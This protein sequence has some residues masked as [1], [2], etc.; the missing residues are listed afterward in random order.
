MSQFYYDLH[1]HSCLSPCADNDN[2]P[3]NIAG[4][5]TLN[6]LQIMALTDHNTCKNCPAFFT[7]AQRQGIIPVPGMELTT[8]EDIH[9]VCLFPTLEAAM[10]F[11]G[12]IDRRRM[13]IPNRPD[14]FGEQLLTDGDDAVIGSEPDYLPNAT[15]VTVEES[16]PLAEAFGGICYPAHIDRESNGILAVLGTLP[17]SPRFSCVEL[18]DG[19]R[20]ADIRAR[21]LSPATRTVVCGDAHVL[22]EIRE[23]ERFLDIDAPPDDEAAVR[24]GLIE[25]L[26]HG[27]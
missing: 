2:T 24:R 18:R 17:E 19:D 5:G 26:R 10:R 7:A 8:A 13:K 15:S 14:I 27:Q 6:G 1:I 20:E 11:D 9:M 25:L 21:Y 3:G 23:R 4:M 16:V 22:W 12:E